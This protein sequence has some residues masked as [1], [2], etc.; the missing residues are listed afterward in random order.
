VGVVIRTWKSVGNGN[1][2]YIA[3]NVKL[4]MEF[5]PFECRGVA[6]PFHTQPQKMFV[7]RGNTST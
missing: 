7:P 4:L 1:K 5:D 6:T 2:G 3:E